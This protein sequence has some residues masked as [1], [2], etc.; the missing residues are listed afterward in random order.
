MPDEAE[1]LLVEGDPVDLE[2]E[3]HAVRQ[4]NLGNRVQVLRDGEETLDY[5]FCRNRFSTRSFE[6]PPKL[7]L[8]DLK[9]PK[10]DA[11]EVLRELRSDP[12]TR[13]I[14]VMV[15]T[16]SPEERDLINSYELG[17]SGCLE[18]PVDFGR[19]RQTV[20][21]GELSPMVVKPPASVTGTNS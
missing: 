11:L 5:L 17:V 16:S 21:Q 9:L 2:L 13:S 10:L 7:V 8:L 14:Q 20:D 12:R 6:S 18:K 4:N 19:L 1:I 15:L 3:L